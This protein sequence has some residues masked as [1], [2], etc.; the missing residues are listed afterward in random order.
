MNPFED[1]QQIAQAMS[2]TNGSTMVGNHLTQLFENYF[3]L[4]LALALTVTV[5]LWKRNPPCIQQSH[6][7]PLQ[8]MPPDKRKLIAVAIAAFGFVTLGPLLSD[9]VFSGWSWYKMFR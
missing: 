5:I 3:V 6:K 7:D 4:A 2:T 9:L 1:P 8:Q